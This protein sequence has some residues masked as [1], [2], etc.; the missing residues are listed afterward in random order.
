VT[1]LIPVVNIPPQSHSSLEVFMTCPKQYY[2]KYVARDVKFQPSYASEWGDNAHKHLEL[3]IKAGGNYTIPDER[4]K[5]TGQSMRDYQWVADA[6]L[7]RAAQRGGYVLAERQFAV[8][9]TRTVGQGLAFF[10]FFS[11]GHDRMLV[12]AGR[13]VGTQEFLQLI[14]ISH[15]L[16]IGQDNV[17]AVD[18]SNLTIGRGLKYI[19]GIFSSRFLHARTH[20]RRFRFN[21]WYG[22]ALHVRTHECA[23]GVVMLE[24]RN[25]GSG[26]GNNLGGR[27]IDIV[28]FLSADHTRFAEDTG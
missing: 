10:H 7:N 9:N 27:N 8:F 1:D 5:D 22:L 21:A 11:D 15:A 20:E 14:F 6:L 25:T 13:R 26:H 23:S 12:D 28:D 4:H 18:F 2:H 17:V 24:E 16:L 19:T 3:Y